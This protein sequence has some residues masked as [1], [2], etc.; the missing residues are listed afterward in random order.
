[1][2]IMNKTRTTVGLLA[3]LVAAQPTRQV[4]A[5]TLDGNVTTAGTFGKAAIPLESGQQNVSYKAAAFGDTGGYLWADR[6][7]DDSAVAVSP[8]GLALGDFTIG[9]TAST[10]PIRLDLNGGNLSAVNGGLST[11]RT[12]NSTAGN[13]TLHNVGQINMGNG[14][15]SASH[16][17][18]SGS[19]YDSGGVNIGQDGIAGPR[20]ASIQIAMIEAGASRYRGHIIIHS[21]NDVLIVNADNQPGDLYNWGLPS[22]SGKN[23]QVL[24]HG[25]FRADTVG[26]IEYTRANAGADQH[27]V[28]FN[29][30]VLGGGTPI[31]T[32]CAGNILTRANLSSVATANRVFHSDHV[33]ISNYAS[34]SVSG[35]IET[36]TGS[37][38]ATARCTG[39]S[40]NITIANIYGD[41]VVAGEIDASSNASGNPVANRGVLTMACGGTISLGSLDMDKVNSASLTASSGTIV[42]GELLNFDTVGGGAGSE[43]D[44]VLTTQ[45]ALR[46]PSGQA[47]FYDPE[48]NPSL[49]GKVYRVADLAGTA[50]QGGLLMPKKS[51][52]GT[53]IVVR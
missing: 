32:F 48:A 15:I 42:S 17:Y 34:L 19:N 7:G 5:A 33:A 18:A 2:R 50:A 43:A 37:Y 25:S 35:N 9:N 20:A 39:K 13:I 45:T 24:H 36:A 38:H 14:Q 49:E 22:L 1:M 10:S 11:E 29:G 26:T 23:I 21:S 28:V 41:V 4:H 3:L 44:P 51:T 31:G 47:I 46:A 12:A 27:E 53:V 30:W 52:A 6:L 40:G 8:P 16:Y